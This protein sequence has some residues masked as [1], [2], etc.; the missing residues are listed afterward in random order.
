M[1]RHTFLTTITLAAGLFWAAG[2][3]AFAQAPGGGGRGGFGMNL[4]EDQRAKMTEAMQ[5]LRTELAPLNEKLA[6]AQK[7]A[8]KAAMAK[9]PDEKAVRAK[10]EAVQKIQTDIGMAR[11]KAMKGVMD[12]L[13]EEQKTQI[14]ERPGIAY[15]MFLGPG[16]GGGMG[17]GGGRRGGGGGG[18]GNQ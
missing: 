18:G 14:N 6:A 4:T 5:G 3:Q 15:N 17:M 8:L 7:E 2:S 11:M 12:S 9:N 13:T 10:V 16:F 1:K